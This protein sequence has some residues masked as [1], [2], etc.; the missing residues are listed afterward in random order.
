MTGPQGKSLFLRMELFNYTL[1]FK[2]IQHPFFLN[3]SVFAVSIP[4]FVRINHESGQTICGLAW[5]PKGNKELAYTD[6]Q[7]SFYLNQS[8]SLSTVDTTYQMTVAVLLY[9]HGSVDIKCPQL[10]SSGSLFPS[11]LK[12]NQH[13]FSPNKFQYTV[14]Q[15]D[16]EN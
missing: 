5:N 3:S 12:S 7:V 2:S 4:L 10:P 6:N 9:V 1:K 15:K 16:Y 8:S 13:R 11:S 14:T